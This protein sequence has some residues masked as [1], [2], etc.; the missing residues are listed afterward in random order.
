[1]A[2]SSVKIT[3]QKCTLVQVCYDVSFCSLLCLNV[4]QRYLNS[5]ITPGDNGGVHINAGIINLAFYLLVRGGSHPR[6]DTLQTGLVVEGIGFEAAAE[7]VSKL[8]SL[9]CYYHS[10]TNHFTVL[11]CQCKLSNSKSQ[12]L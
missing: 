11:Q 7:I 9:L 5:F 6:E 2:K 4:L 3:I 12:I 1:M 10:N 8:W